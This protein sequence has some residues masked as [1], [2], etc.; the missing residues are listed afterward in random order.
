MENS[1]EL[2]NFLNL[3]FNSK[4][5]KVSVLFDSETEIQTY[6]DSTFKIRK[7]HLTN[8]FNFIL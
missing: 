4:L 7:A 6:N 2:Y 3:N 1:L 5:L 8:K